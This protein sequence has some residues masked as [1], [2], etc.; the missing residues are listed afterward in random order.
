[1]LTL[2][3]RETMSHYGTDIWVTLIPWECVGPDLRMIADL[4]CI[5]SD[6]RMEWK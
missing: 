3:I 6:T 1:M 2:G 5:V 4:V